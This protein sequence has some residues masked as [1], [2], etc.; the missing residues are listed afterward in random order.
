MI[1]AAVRRNAAKLRRTTD[2]FA[3]DRRLAF[4]EYRDQI[5]SGGLC[6]EID[7]GSEH[8]TLRGDKL[9]FS[10]ESVV[11]ISN[12]GSECSFPKRWMNIVD[13]R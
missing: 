12:R 10:V 11:L 5:K 7:M 1:I 9:L 13:A 3:D 4:T 6:I 8:H 2:P